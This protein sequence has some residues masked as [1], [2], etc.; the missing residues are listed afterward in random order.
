MN[1]AGFV[2]LDNLLRLFS[3]DEPEYSEQEVRRS[4]SELRSTDHRSPDEIEVKVSR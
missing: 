4:W 2:H 1:H 3:Y